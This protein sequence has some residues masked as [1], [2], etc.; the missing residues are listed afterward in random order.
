LIRGARPLDIVAYLM[1]ANSRHQ[2]SQQ[3]PKVDIRFE[4]RQ[5]LNLHHAITFFEVKSPGSLQNR[6]FL[7]ALMWKRISDT[8]YAWCASPIA[9]HPSV[10]RSDER[11]AVRAEVAR[12]IR[13]T[14]ISVGVTKVEYACTMDLKGRMPTWV[15]NRVALPALM[16]LPYKLQTYFAQIRP[17]GDCTAEDGEFIGHMLM[18]TALKTPTAQR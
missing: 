6:T 9:N 13:L 3:D 12:C 17:I 1:D 15:T 5:V 18:D 4:T 16:A 7:N 10:E 14:R 11:H 8:Q 2:Q